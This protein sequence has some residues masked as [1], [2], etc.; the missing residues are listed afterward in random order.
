M[1]I[2]ANDLVLRAREHLLESDESVKFTT[3]RLYALIPSAL[4]KWIE[5]TGK[6]P[7]K[8]LNFLAETADITVTAG[9]ADVESAIEAKGIQAQFVTGDHIVFSYGGNPNLAIQMVNSR[10]R[11]RLGGIQDRFFVM[12]YFDGKKMYF[13]NPADGALNSFSGTFKI[14]SVA[15]PRDLTDIPNSVEGELASILAEVARAYNVEG[16]HKGVALNMAKER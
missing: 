16:E 15:V 10:D 6:D 14:R 3:E 12:V 9:V 5:R 7:R 8:R 13:R 1:A 4:S 11:L 2:D